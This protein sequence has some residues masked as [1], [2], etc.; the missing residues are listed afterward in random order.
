[1][2]QHISTLDLFIKTASNAVRSDKDLELESLP[3][4]T[5][6]SPKCMKLLAATAGLLSGGMVSKVCR[7]PFA[8]PL[9]VQHDANRSASHQHPVLKI[10]LKF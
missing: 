1:M 10:L 6:T 3:E 5:F 9:L 8:T 2:T 7:S 4:E